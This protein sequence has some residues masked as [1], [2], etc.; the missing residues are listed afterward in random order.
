MRVINTATLKLEWFAGLP[1]SQNGE[2]KDF[3]IL[4]HTWGANEVT[5]KEFADPNVSSLTG[6]HKVKQTCRLARVMGISYAWIDSCC[7]D[8]S[9][10]TELSEAINSMFKWYSLAKVAYAYLD[11]WDR[12]AKLDS[13]KSQDLKKCKWFTRGWTLQE[14]IA[15]KEILFYDA[16]WT[17]QGSKSSL[18][19]HLSRITN[20]EKQIL[21]NTRS[22][23]QVPVATRM[24]WA[25]HR[26]TTI[27]EDVAYC[28][29]GIFDVNI[30]MLYGEGATKAFIRLQEAILSSV[31]DLTLF[32][33]QA[34]PEDQ[35]KYRGVFA[36]QPNEFIRF[37]VFE[38]GHDID[39]GLKT[40]VAPG[41]S[42]EF[43]LTNK[44]VR[45]EAALS[46]SDTVLS[47]ETTS[48][49]YFPE[50][51][52]T[53][54]GIHL[55]KYGAGLYARA[56]PHELTKFFNS[57]SHL[58][59]HSTVFLS[60]DLSEEESVWLEEEGPSRGAIR[61][62]NFSTLDFYVPVVLHPRDRWVDSEQHFLAGRAVPCGGYI[63]FRLKQWARNK[64]GNQPFTLFFCV[65]EEFSKPAISLE[66]GELEEKGE[67]SLPKIE[68]YVSK[69]STQLRILHKD[70][71][72][73]KNYFISAKVRTVE[74]DEITKYEIVIK[75]DYRV[76]WIS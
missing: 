28:L 52:T 73:L 31:N 29:I 45:L 42:R 3:A 66:P 11:D 30:P 12:E 59:P 69:G 16:S 2:L 60:R 54:L 15:P 41:F 64:D 22:L 1:Q 57:V 70:L 7:I 37:S 32:A 74:Q 49:R 65:M 9:S 4:S 53:E 40:N 25:A 61:F 34:K 20:I 44:G 26:S 46:S 8:K 67:L 76:R 19:A 58:G 13:G 14:L 39:L 17:L 55:K 72:T 75:D 24:S 48:V 38:N 18:V 21:K 56:R 33:W 62:P 51:L 50:K 27:E 71:Q 43:T 5:F 47:V 36:R 6:Y 68:G 10:S 35:Q 63:H 23:R